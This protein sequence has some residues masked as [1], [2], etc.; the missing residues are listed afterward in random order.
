MRALNDGFGAPLVVSSRGGAE[1]GGANL[2]PLGRETL[3][4]YR[5]MQARA[6]AAIEDDVNALR[7]MIADISK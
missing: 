7:A 2:T 1:Q 4:R 3:A 5:A 6:E